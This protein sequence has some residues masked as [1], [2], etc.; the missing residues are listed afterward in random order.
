MQC[1]DY[2]GVACVDGRCPKVQAEEY[3]EFGMTVIRNCADCFFYEGCKDCAL[4]G[5]EYCD[6]S[7]I[8]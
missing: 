3:E 5:T 1:R 8:N 7:E 6:K 4:S 2:V